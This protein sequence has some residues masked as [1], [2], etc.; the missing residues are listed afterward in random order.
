MDNGI[1]QRNVRVNFPMKTPRTGLEI[2]DELD[3]NDWVA[4]WPGV[5]LPFQPFRRGRNWLVPVIK[6]IR[7][8]TD[9]DAVSFTWGPVEDVIATG[10]G[11]Y[12][13]SFSI[14][15]DTQPT[16]E[17]Q[18]AVWQWRNISVWL[19]EPDIPV[20]GPPE[21]MNPPNA[22]DYYEDVNIK[23]FRPMLL[24]Q[25]FYNINNIPGTES[26]YCLPNGHAWFDFDIEY[27]IMDWIT[28]AREK[29]R[30]FTTFR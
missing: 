12:Q 10:G 18:F 19:P 25:N 22:V 29:N 26:G 11:A 20:S 17:D 2:F 8:V 7:F 13:Q 14:Q 6:R 16:V 9:F 30:D 21:V 28:F 23:I 15:P 1:G 5:Q 4:I 3:Y 24:T 27:E